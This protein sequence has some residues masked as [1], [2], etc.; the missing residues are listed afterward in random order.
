MISLPL[1]YFSMGCSIMSLISWKSSFSTVTRIMSST[2]LYINTSI[3][4]FVLSDCKLLCL[5]EPFIVKLEDHVII[6][7]M[8]NYL[9]IPLQGSQVR[10]TKYLLRNGL[11][12]LKLRNSL[13][14][15][16]TQTH[17]WICNL[18]TVLVLASLIYYGKKKSPTLSFH[19]VWF[20]FLVWKS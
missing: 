20:G 12:E 9:W 14:K 3:V 4:I 2:Y 10:Q 7:G 5:C 1:Y 18:P 11:F 13:M 16:L 15:C 6:S 8:L 19:S 17:P